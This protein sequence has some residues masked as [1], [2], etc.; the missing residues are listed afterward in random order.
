M[1]DTELKKILWRCRRGTKELDLILES[2]AEKRYGSL[3]IDLREQFDKLL[4][5]QDP[6]LT[7]W[8]CYKNTPDTEFRKIVT[9][10]LKATPNSISN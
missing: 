4:Q 7:D 8:L 2:F 5:I 3:D 1:S 9:E 6:V 10:V